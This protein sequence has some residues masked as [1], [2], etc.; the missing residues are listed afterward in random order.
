MKESI[1]EDSDEE[2]TGGAGQSL[3]TTKTF[4]ILD[5][6]TQVTN[7]I[8]FDRINQQN[9]DNL[10]LLVEWLIGAWWHVIPSRICCYG[11]SGW[12]LTV[13]STTPRVPGHK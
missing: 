5:V 8:Q 6:F 1:D 3:K 12:T 11:D 2:D 4:H 10:C 7:C 9:P 13:S